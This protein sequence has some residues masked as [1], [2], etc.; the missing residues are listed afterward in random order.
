MF[1]VYILKSIAFGTYYVGSTNDIERRIRQHNSG[2]SFYTRSKRPWKLCY[3]D[4]FDSL[5]DARKRENQIKSWKK[6]KAIEKLIY[7]SSLRPKI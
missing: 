3:T 4:A 1:F 5:S 6:R 7:S 2:Y